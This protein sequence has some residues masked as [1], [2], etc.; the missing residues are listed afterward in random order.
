V[1]RHAACPVL[2]LPR[3]ATSEHGE[4]EAVADEVSA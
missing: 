4:Q 1:I 3:H 2:V